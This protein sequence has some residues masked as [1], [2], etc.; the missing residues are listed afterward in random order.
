[1]APVSERPFP[2]TVAQLYVLHAVND[3]TEVEGRAPTY[4][5]I[6]DELDHANKARV[7]TICKDLFDRGWF[8]PCPHS[9]GHT[10]VLTRDPPPLPPLPECWIEITPK[11][12]RYLQEGRSQ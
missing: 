1:M 4:Q 12:G 8:E 11:G 10:L 6:A 7:W 5:E 3:L 2:P 9:A